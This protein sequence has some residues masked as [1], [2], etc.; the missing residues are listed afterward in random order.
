M[1]INGLSGSI[2]TNQTADIGALDPAAASR[3]SSVP[4]PMQGAGTAT[5]SPRGQFFSELQELSQQDPTQFKAVAA[6][7]STNFQNAAS[8]ASGP[9]AKLLGSLANQFAQAAQTGSL[10]PPQGGA[11][12]Q[13]TSPAQATQ[14]TRA[15]DGS[16]GAPAPH[17]PHHH[18]YRGGGASEGTGQASEV[19]QAFQNAMNILSQAMQGTSS[20]GAASTSTSTSSSTATTSV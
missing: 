6:Q 20:T 1:N 19:Q 4:P 14:P 13:P 12:S 11:Q 7:L 10:T 3:P 15:A 17:H 5:I 2:A 18:H 16:T 9:Q 8:Q